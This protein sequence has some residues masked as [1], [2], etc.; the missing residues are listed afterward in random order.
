M[1][2][3]FAEPREAGRVV[4][5]SGSAGSLPL[6]VRLRRALLIALLLGLWA[7]VKIAWEMRIEA[8][9][10]R[11]RYHSL[12]ITP[13]LRDQ[14]GQGFSIGVLSGMGSVVADILWIVNVTQ[15]WEDEEWFRIA[16]YID[17]CTTMEPRSIMFWDVG[18]WHLAWNASVFFAHDI[19][20]PN[21]LRR[22]KASRYWIERGLDVYKRG[23]ENNPTSW[24]LCADTGLL[25]QQRLL[26]Y[27]QAAVYYERA[28]E[29]PDVPVFYE[30]FPAIMYHM[31]G[32]DAASYAAWQRLWNRLTP[33]QRTEEM[34]RPTPHELSVLREMETKLS[35]PE[36]KRVFPN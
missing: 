10:N 31:A 5:V 12:V 33:A 4:E 13:H 35:I 2:A 7:P 25:Y 20:E 15:A 14:L 19:H 24:R 29:L 17:L 16:S 8:E 9:Q 28:S 21:P 26:D 23:I 32:D 36:E 3:P 30:R 34:H 22:M 6:S 18:G 27:R 11:L 1:S